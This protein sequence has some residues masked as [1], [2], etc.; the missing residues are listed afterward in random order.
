MGTIHRLGIGAAAVAILLLPLATSAA[1][2]A[3]DPVAAASEVGPT[4]EGSWRPMAA[5]PFRSAFAGGAW[6]GDELVVVDIA[7]ARA[8]AYDPLIDAWT[9]FEPTGAADYAWNSPWTWT[10]SELVIV[11]RHSGRA[12]AFD[13]AAQ[14]WRTLPAAPLGGADAVVAADGHLIVAT[15]DEDTDTLRSARLDLASDTWQQLADMP[16]VLWLVD[17][18]W[19]GDELVTSTTDPAA[20]TAVLLRLAPGADAWERLAPAPVEQLYVLPVWTGT[21]LVFADGTDAVDDATFDL[22][23]DMW[24]EE[25]YDCPASSSWAVWFDDLLFQPYVD[26][27]AYDPAV[28][29]GFGLDP[30]SGACYALTD[31]PIL[32]DYLSMGGSDWPRTPALTTEADGELVLWSGARIGLDLLPGEEPPT[33]DREG[34]IFTPAATE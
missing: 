13:T 10:G 25:R 23:T 2:A 5:S 4:L 28:R 24:T 18:I 11:D 6:I 17:L 26:P 22:L 12:Q 32:I 19:T 15:H 34:I 9:E 27:L 1:E 7:T 3:D 8:A 33:A 30:M 21:E 20:D 16:E 29:P 14:T 31:D